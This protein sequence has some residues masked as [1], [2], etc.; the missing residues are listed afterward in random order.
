MCDTSINCIFKCMNKGRDIA[1]ATHSLADI[2][3]LIRLGGECLN[4]QYSRMCD[5]RHSFITVCVFKTA[6]EFTSL[7]KML[8]IVFM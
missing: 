1:E 5:I 4:F 6:K 8:F 7:K 3:A 2:S